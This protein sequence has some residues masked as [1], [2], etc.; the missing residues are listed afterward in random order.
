M[1]LMNKT[2]ILGF[3]FIL[4]FSIIILMVIYINSTYEAS[5]QL[6]QS[7]IHQ[8]AKSHFENIKMFR[9]WN[10]MYNGVYV[11]SNH[12]IQP[13]PYLKDNHMYS[14]NNEL[15]IRINPAW[16]TRQIAEMMNTQTK[17]K[18]KITSLNPLNPVNLADDFEKEALEY[19][20]KNKD[21]E[22]FT[23]IDHNKSLYELVGKLIVEPS[24]L[25][26]HEEQ[27][28][29]VGDVRG[30][31]RVTI[32]ISLYESSLQ[33]LK[34][35]K[36]AQIGGILILSLIVFV[37]L[38]FTINSFYKKQR[39]LNELKDKYKE[40]YI[41]YDFALNASKLGLWDWN[42]KEQTVFFSPEWK[43]MLG[44]EDNEILNALEEWDKRVHPDDKEKAINDILDNQ[45]K[46]TEYYENIHRL[47][48][49]DG[50]W[51]WILDKGKTIFDQEGNPIRM[52]GVHIDI[53][54][55]EELKI[56][57]NKLKKI[58]EHSPL[59]IV[60]TDENGEIEYVNPWFCK[61][62]GY[63]VEEALGQNPRVLKSGFTSALEYEELWKTLKNK[64][65][66]KGRFKNRRKDGIEFWESAIITPII[67]EKGQITNFLAIK[68]EITKEIYLQEEVKTKDELMISQSRHA[69]MGEMVSLIAH[70]WRQPIA[71]VSMIANNMIMDL[72]FGEV[73][74]ENLKEDAQS[75]LDQTQYLSQT[76][77]DFRDFFK[78]DK[79]KE[80][81]KIKTVLSETMSIF[82][83]ALENNDITLVVDCS[84]DIEINIYSRELLQVII[85]L[86]KNAKEA[87]EN[88]NIKDKRIE[89]TVQSFSSYI[90]IEM[91]D[92]A[93]KIDENIKERIFE[94][95][96]STKDEQMG[97][98][99]GLYMSKTI[100]EKH[101]GGKLW[102]ENKNEGVSFYVD[103]PTK[104][105]E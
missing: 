78:P 2:A 51:V 23:R 13:N 27:G 20:E 32:P 47:K 35:H 80:V 49:K 1:K 89:I 75:L 71:V 29:Q 56:E 97:T 77:D 48:H 90:R 58:I 57:L 69:A 79:A 93:A 4:I 8:E 61:V 98:G 37:V 85:N 91:Y 105:N 24:C 21:K 12:Q 95:Y 40:L 53:T 50:S 96:F 9:A 22:Y 99:L 5:K 86:L 25:Q 30:G 44:Y 43:R 14:N 52:M 39:H 63:S 41:N 101:L 83:K 68:Q 38:Y 81:T 60:I 66:W 102:C 31:I 11:K 42:L 55:S 36:N 16:M 76:I 28:Y 62:T 19:F 15:L 45:N 3:F 104:S 10:S 92:N 82:G 6:L 64:Q 65:L 18:Y 67:N 54:K 26:C 17:Y 74:N 46:K 73:N 7:T 100:I 70:Q 72:E 84:D 34:F 33:K 103:L 88:K 59:S 94:P 87:F